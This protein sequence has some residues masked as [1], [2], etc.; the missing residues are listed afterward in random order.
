MQPVKR[1][2]AAQRDVVGELGILEDLDERTAEHEVLFDLL[3]G[4]PPRGRPPL[5]DEV[6]RDHTST[7]MV[8]LTSTRQRAFR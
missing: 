5:D 7:S 4:C 1:G 8:V 2:P 3:V 6:G